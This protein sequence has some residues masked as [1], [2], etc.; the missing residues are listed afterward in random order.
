MEAGK[1]GA[2]GRFHNWVYI[3]VSGFVYL[4]PVK[5][6]QTRIDGRTE[7]TGEEERGTSKG[8]T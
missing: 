8:K 3:F 2:V 5:E 4:I 7:R 1:G 6:D